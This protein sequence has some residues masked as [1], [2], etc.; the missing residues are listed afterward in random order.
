MPSHCCF[1][2][3]QDNAPCDAPC[4]CLFFSVGSIFLKNSLLS[5][6]SFTQGPDLGFLRSRLLRRLTYLRQHSHILSC[7][8]LASKMCHERSNKFGRCYSY[9]SHSRC[10]SL[11][12][13]HST[14]SA[15]LAPFYRGLTAL[16]LRHAS[17][18]PPEDTVWR[19][20]FASFCAEPG[21]MLPRAAQFPCPRLAQF[22][23]GFHTVAQ[24]SCA[25]K[26]QRPTPGTCWLMQ[27][28]LEFCLSL[29]TS[30]IP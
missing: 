21:F 7:G 11:E 20:C 28:A 6:T 1:L 12:K 25:G 15:L 23:G 22:W 10:R 8:T 13:A 5:F 9:T 2:G 3:V 24:S 4:L 19:A 29:S 14:S 27:P 17:L 18:T 16:L 30:L 26:S